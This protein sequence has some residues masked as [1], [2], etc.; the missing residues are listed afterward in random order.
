[1][2]PMML[3][4]RVDVDTLYGLS[5]G[6]PRLLNLFAE[7][8]IRATFFIPMG[9]DRMGRNAKRI[10]RERGLEVSLLPYLRIYNWRTFVN[11]T[12]RTSPSFAD[13]GAG[14]MLRIKRE[15]HDVGLHSY[16]HYSWQD[17]IGEYSAVDIEDDFRRC[18]VNYVRVFGGL[19]R[20]CAAP[21]WRAT[22]L[23]LSTQEGYGFDYASD[24][25]GRDPFYPSVRGVKLKTLQIP[26]SL[27]TLDELLLEGG[28]S[29][30]L[31][32]SGAHVYCA[33]AEIEGLRELAWLRQLLKRAREE[34]ASVVPLS[35][36]ARR[37]S[38]SGHARVSTGTVPGRASPVALKVEV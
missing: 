19:P 30:V 20:C 1:M 25:R 9:P 3:G 12:I 36:F 21:G 23:S 34:G 24:T 14:M 2:H 13:A 22:E 4:L 17:K 35:T 26:V 27:P 28:K 11:G 5:K 7:L 37:S 18:I 16:D 38:G 15:G 33:H 10:V 31:P 32:G 6:V 29:L 8:G